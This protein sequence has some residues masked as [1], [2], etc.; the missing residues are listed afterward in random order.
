MMHVN[1]NLYNWQLFED[2]NKS[3]FP[4]KWRPTFLWTVPQ[5][6]KLFANHMISKMIGEYNDELSLLNGDF[7]SV[8]RMSRSTR[9]GLHYSRLDKA[10]L[11]RYFADLICHHSASQPATNGLRPMKLQIDHLRTAVW[12]RMPWTSQAVHWY[13]IHRTFPWCFTSFLSWL[14]YL[15]SLVSG[16]IARFLYSLFC[17]PKDRYFVQ[18][19]SHSPSSH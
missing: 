19:P 12:G 2:I 17:P 4:P 10:T 15:I 5:S 6:L 11:E 1:I 7:N 18:P 3:P 16:N 13:V 14:T 9:H 8:L